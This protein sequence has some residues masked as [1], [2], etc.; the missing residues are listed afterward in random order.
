MRPCWVFVSIDDPIAQNVY[1]DLFAPRSPE[2]LSSPK[3]ATCAVIRVWAGSWEPPTPSSTSSGGLA[4]PR[5]SKLAMIV[6]DAQRE[7]RLILVCR[8]FRRGERRVPRMGRSVLSVVLLLIAASCGYFAVA[9]LEM[10]RESWWAAWTIAGIVGLPCFLGAMWLLL[11]RKT[12]AKPREARPRD[13]HRPTADI[14]DCVTTAVLCM[15]K[16]SRSTKPGG[17]QGARLV[18]RWGLFSLVFV[19]SQPRQSGRLD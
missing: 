6:G 2:T 11:P 5:P 15:M 3:P 1:Y 8:G 16:P 10:P 9:T 12:R 13:R 4:L 14:S 7:R 19:A 17:L 18:K